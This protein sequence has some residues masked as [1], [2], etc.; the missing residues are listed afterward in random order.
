MLPAKPV[1]PPGVRGLRVV[2]AGI[3]GV[4]VAPETQVPGRTEGKVGQAKG[5]LEESAEKVGDAFK[6]D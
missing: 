4:D 5:H 1:D 3:R 2:W 6:K